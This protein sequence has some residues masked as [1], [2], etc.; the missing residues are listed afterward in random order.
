MKDGMNDY[1]M[2]ASAFPCG[3]ISGRDFAPTEKLTCIYGLDQNFS[4]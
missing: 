2:T 4:L 3:D 1:S